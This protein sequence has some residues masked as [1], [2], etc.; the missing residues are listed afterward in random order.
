[1]NDSYV[2][3]TGRLELRPVAWGDLADLTALKADPRVFAMMLG[4]VRT[5]QRTQAEL[6]EDIAFW[7]RSGVGMWT[8]REAGRFIGVAGIME[9]P[10]G[11]GLALR[12]GLRPEA[13]GRGLAREAAAAALRFAH[14]Q[15]VPRVIAV[16]REDNFAS[17]MVLGGIGMRAGGTFPRDGHV[18]VVYE[19]KVGTLPQT[20]SGGA[21]PTP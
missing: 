6:A 3:H 8:V 14:G 13:R 16:A 5:A 1:M 18:M 4:G 15:G 12:F 20:P 10:D 2:L 19:S 21:A 9:R 7:A 11:R 17:R